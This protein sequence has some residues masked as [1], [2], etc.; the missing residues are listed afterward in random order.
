MKE[1]PQKEGPCAIGLTGAR[2]SREP[3]YMEPRRLPVFDGN[4]LILLSVF[5]VGGS[6]E[7]D[8]PSRTC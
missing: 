1:L 7:V 8:A 2:T 3:V 4:Q 6:I 5:E